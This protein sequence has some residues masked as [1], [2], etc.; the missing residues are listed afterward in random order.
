M[1]HTHPLQLSLTQCYKLRAEW[2]GVSRPKTGFRFASLRGL[3]S[4]FVL[5]KR[6]S[7][8]Q[9]SALKRVPHASGSNH[10]A[11]LIYSRANG[12]TGLGC[13]DMPDRIISSMRREG[14]EMVGC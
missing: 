2:Q 4:L 3:P 6:S 1:K 9:A 11:C 10:C 7:V 5:E 13:E 8:L 12:R 14:R